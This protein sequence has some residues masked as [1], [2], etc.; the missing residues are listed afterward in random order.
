MEKRSHGIVLGVIQVPHSSQPIIQLSDAQSSG[1]YPKVGTVIQA[2]LWRLAQVPIGAMLY[3]VK[4]DYASAVQAQADVDRYLE[5]VRQTVSMHRSQ[6][7]SGKKI[8]VHW[9]TGTFI[10]ALWCAYFRRCGIW[11]R[12]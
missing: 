3:F 11:K 1:G 6:R 2:D 5:R 10:T 8:M 4:T 12:R 9:R 7:R